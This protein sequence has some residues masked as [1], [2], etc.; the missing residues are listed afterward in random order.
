MLHTQHIPVHSAD[1][2]TPSAADIERQHLMENFSNEEGMRRYRDSLIREVKHSDGTVTRSQVTLGETKPGMRIIKDVLG[3]P[4]D[5][6]GLIW[7]IDEIRKEV[8]TPRKGRRNDWE[9]V[10]A[11]MPSDQLALITLRVLLNIPANP[12]S[13]DPRFFNKTSMRSTATNSSR[14]MMSM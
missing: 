7:A 5:G 12:R 1:L 14:I 6:K 13:G 8:L 9:T 2:P 10:V 11:F 4:K 3:T